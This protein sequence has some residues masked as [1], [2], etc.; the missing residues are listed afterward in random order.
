LHKILKKIYSKVNH[1]LKRFPQMI[2]SI[3]A[4]YE[5]DPDFKKL[6]DEYENVIDIV[7]NLTTL[8]NI[9]KKSI[10]NQIEQEKE[11]LNTLEKEIEYFLQN[12]K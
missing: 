3:K 1:L 11:L 10:E 12:E 7:D 8:A 9:P 4:F 2:N 6:C 5:V